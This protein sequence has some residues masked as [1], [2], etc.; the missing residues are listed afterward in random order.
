MRNH[1]IRKEELDNLKYY[2]KR[3]QRTEAAFLSDFNNYNINNKPFIEIILP[4]EEHPQRTHCSSLKEY[5]VQRNLNFK[6]VKEETYKVITGF[7]PHLKHFNYCPIIKDLPSLKKEIES[8]PY[9][10][11]F[12]NELGFSIN[13]TKTNFYI[14][15]YTQIDNVLGNLLCPIF[16]NSLYN[17]TISKMRKTISRKYHIDE[18]VGIIIDSL[19]KISGVNH[20]TKDW[21]EIYSHELMQKKTDAYQFFGEPC[22]HGIQ[23]YSYYHE[24]SHYILE[25]FQSNKDSMQKEI[26]ADIISLNLLVLSA[27]MTKDSSVNQIIETWE[28]SYLIGPLMFHYSKLIE[29]HNN[30][31]MFE[32]YLFRYAYIEILIKQIMEI[33]NYKPGL[34]LYC[35]I[36]NLFLRT[37]ETLGFEGVNLTQI[38][39]NKFELLN[40]YKIKLQLLNNGKLFEFNHSEEFVSTFH[41]YIEI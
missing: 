16:Y 25:H 34:N 10:T 41:N 1:E 19:S 23:Y 31:K 24:Y 14:K 18:I 35:Q 9:V 28:S 36:H 22:S 6:Q 29:I 7:L 39:I 32:N 12:S 40:D 13:R 33:R 37:M 26:E 17:L 2:L 11:W 8:I 38:I 4:K 21:D 15:H 20:F 3:L 30:Q 27:K 5:L